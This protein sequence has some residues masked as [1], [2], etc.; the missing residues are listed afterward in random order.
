MPDRL[1][2]AGRSNGR[3]WSDSSLRVN[4]ARSSNGRTSDSESE[5]LGS[6]P[7]LA[8]RSGSVELPDGLALLKK[9]R[10]TDSKPD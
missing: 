10:K 6:N 9:E 8:A 5:Y 7:S 3:T 4:I 1:P 2:A